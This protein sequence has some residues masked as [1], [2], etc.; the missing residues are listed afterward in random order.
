LAKIP[1]IAPTSFRGFLVAATD[2]TSS[3]LSRILHLLALHPDVQDQLRKELKEAFEDNEL[4]HDQ[5]VSLPFLEAVCRE[6]LR[7]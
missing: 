2:T 4:T 3:A 5:L 7:L 1:L 6:S